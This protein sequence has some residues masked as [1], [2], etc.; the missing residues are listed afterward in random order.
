MGQNAE[1]PVF[2]GENEQKSK[3]PHK[4]WRFSAFCPDPLVEKYPLELLIVSTVQI[5]YSSTFHFFE[6]D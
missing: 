6:R 5:N 1:S 4:T 2:S 3:K